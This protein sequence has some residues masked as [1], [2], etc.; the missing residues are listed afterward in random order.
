MMQ[1]MIEALWR[2]EDSFKRLLKIG[3]Q[4]VPVSISLWMA[5]SR[6][7]DNRHHLTDISFGLF[8]GAICAV[9]FYD[10][11]VVRLKL[12]PQADENE[13]K[14]IVSTMNAKCSIMLHPDEL[15]LT[16][17]SAASG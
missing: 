5:G 2:T 17:F 13:E 8:L 3:A 15:R 11:L 1:M 9:Y 6:Y 16:S 7:S 4:L 12:L 10:R 14:S